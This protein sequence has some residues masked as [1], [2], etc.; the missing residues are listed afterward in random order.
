[1]PVSPVVPVA[2]VEVLAAV[3]AVE[4]VVAGGAPVSAVLPDGDAAV[5]PEGDVTLV[6]AV[7]AVGAR[8][9]VPVGE[10]GTVAESVGEGF[11]GG[12]LA[13]PPPQPM[14]KQRREAVCR[15]DMRD[16]IRLRP[17]RR[18]RPEYVPITKRKSIA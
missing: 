17:R 5:S 12:A 8:V 6:S 14:T 15:F 1:M 2:A 4:A 13:P 3:S 16:S 9:D 10:V 11:G 7:E 18:M